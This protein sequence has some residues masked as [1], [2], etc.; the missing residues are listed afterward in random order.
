M[1]GE[2]ERAALV[3]GDKEHW[4][5]LVS[6]LWRSDVTAFILKVNQSVKNG[7]HGL[8]IL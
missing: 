7:L 8:V 2:R 3:S 6:C 4:M 1:H 5:K